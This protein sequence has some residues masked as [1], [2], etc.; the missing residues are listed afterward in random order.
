MN[1]KRIL[2]TFFV[3]VYLTVFIKPYLPIINYAIN[4]D[5]IAAA[6]CENKDKPMMHCNGKC[7]LAKELKK[8][9]KEESKNQTTRILQEDFVFTC[10]DVAKDVFENIPGDSFGINSNYTNNYSFQNISLPYHPPKV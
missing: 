10:T 6:L 8:T 4:K 2:S 5:Y 3:L 9:A 1:L 7:H